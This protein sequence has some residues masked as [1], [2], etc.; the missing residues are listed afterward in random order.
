MLG[1]GPAPPVAMETKQG[2]RRPPERGRARAWVGEGR[3][4]WR[5]VALATGL[6][7]PF[8]SSG[9]WPVSR[10]P[11]SAAFPV[12]PLLSFPWSAP[13]LM[14]LFP[15]FLT[16]TPLTT[17]VGFP[18]SSCWKPPG[19]LR[20]EGAWRSRPASGAC[21][22]MKGT[23]RVRAAHLVPRG[24]SPGTRAPFHTP[25]APFHASCGRMPTVGQALPCQGFLPSRKQ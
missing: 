2:R 25:L 3:W 11:P 4:G 8:A 17:V 10:D 9:S 19:F 14:S 13:S 12:C 16:P 21:T 20:N 6:R 22:P 5:A 7:R 15:D 24:H 23:R 1:A 18:S